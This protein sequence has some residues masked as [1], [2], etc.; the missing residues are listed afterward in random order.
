[1]DSASLYL[2]SVA[3]IELSQRRW[4]ASPLHIA[5]VAQSHAHS[6]ELNKKFLQSTKQRVPSLRHVYPTLSSSVLFLHT[7]DISNGFIPTLFHPRSLERHVDYTRFHSAL[8]RFTKRGLPER[9]SFAR[10][11]QRHFIIEIELSADI[12]GL[13][14]LD[15][16]FRRDMQLGLDYTYVDILT[17]SST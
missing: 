6:Y 4:R 13:A 11:D 8:D 16:D 3:P 9:R 7:S 17:I 2:H 1:M 12:F 15:Y 5:R 10:V 14:V